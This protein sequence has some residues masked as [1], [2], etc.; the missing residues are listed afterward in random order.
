MRSNASVLPTKKRN[1]VRKNWNESKNVSAS[2]RS[3]ESV[4]VRSVQQMP[5]KQHHDRP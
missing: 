4:N 2:E 3:R 5:R 1:V